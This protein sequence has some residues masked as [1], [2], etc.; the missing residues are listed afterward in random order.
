MTKAEERQ[1]PQ[2]KG[3]MI[4]ESYGLSI[5][6]GSVD[7]QEPRGFAFG[8]DASFR[9]DYGLRD[10]APEVRVSMGAIG[11]HDAKTARRR[12]TSYSMVTFLAETAEMLISAGLDSQ[13]VLAQHLRAAL[14]A[15][16]YVDLYARRAA[17]RKA[18][19]QSDA[20]FLDH[21]EQRAEGTE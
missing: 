15:Q 9:L 20:R 3:F 6:V 5:D 17:D 14:E 11:A 19:E 21:Q 13:A 10:G 16:G 7:P 1:E 2:E 12:A 18:Q 4:Q 8:E